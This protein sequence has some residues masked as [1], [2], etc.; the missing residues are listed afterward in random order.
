MEKTGI[1]RN[2][3]DKDSNWKSQSDNKSTSEKTT[4]DVN[5]SENIFIVGNLLWPN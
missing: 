5:N 4:L 1:G 3:G 2:K